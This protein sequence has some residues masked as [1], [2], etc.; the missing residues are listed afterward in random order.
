MY[1]YGVVADLRLA[2]GGTVGAA[3]DEHRAVRA[4]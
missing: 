4:L 3:L 1:L 2:D